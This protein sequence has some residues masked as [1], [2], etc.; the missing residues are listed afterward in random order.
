MHDPIGGF[1]RI[2]DLY[3][4]YL[5]TAFR[6]RDPGV[7]AERRAL[8]E[9]PG[10]LCTEPLVEPVP[11]YAPSGVGLHDLVDGPAAERVLPGFSRAQRLAFAE[12]ALAGLFDATPAADG[13]ATSREAAYPLYEH[14]ATML[15]RGVQQGRPGVVTSGTGS[16]KTE[17]FL[18]PILASIVREATSWD[19]P[20]PGYLGRRWWHGDDGR[21]AGWS[22]LPNRPT[23]ADPGATPFRPH[24][25]GERRPA[26]VRALVLYPMNAL[27]EDQLTRVRK[28]LDSDEARRVMDRHLGGNRIFFGRYTSAAPVTG[29]HVHPRPAADEPDRRARKLR[30]LL[31][32]LGEVERTQA[33]ARAHDAA[34][35]RDGRDE[36]PTRFLFPSTD[37][38]EL[39]T[40]WDMQ[41]TPP[42]LLVTN[43]SMLNAMLVRE[44][45]A[46]VFETTRAWLES[47]PDAYFYLVLDELHLQRGSAGTEVAYLLRVLLDRLGLTR[48]EH[49]HKLR[50]LASSASLPVDG[51]ER[52]Q[53]LRYLYDAFGLHGT[54]TAGGPPAQTGPEAWADAVV[55]GEPVRP[56]PAETG[57]LPSEPFLALLDAYG[58]ADRTAFDAPTAHEDDWRA[59][60]TALGLTPDGPAAHVAGA[61]VAEAGARLA[62]ACVGDPARPGGDPVPRATPTSTLAERL[63]GAS[64]PDA[65]RALRGLLV[66]RGAGGPLRGAWADDRALARRVDQAPSFR[67]HTFFRAVEGL[68]AAPDEAG[69]VESP[70]RTDGRS[71]GPL[72][73]ERGERFAKRADRTRGHRVLELLYCECC[74]ET[75]YG[76]RRGVPPGGQADG[77]QAD[78]VELLPHEPEVAGLPDASRTV[79]FEDLSY[80]EFAVFWPSTRTPAE[81]RSGEPESGSWVP[82][83]LDPATGVVRRSLLGG[84]G[85]PG[86]LYYRPPGYEDSQHHLVNGDD[87]TAVPFACPFCGTN[88]GRR[89]RSMRLSPI[90]SFRAGFAKTTQILATEL[91]DALRVHQDDAKLLSFS[92]SRQEASRAA[93][94]VESGH[95]ADLRLDLL[96]GALRQAARARRADDPDEL[97]RL[98]TEAA[99]DGHYDLA[100]ALKARRL[101]AEAGSSDDAVPMS[102][103]VESLQA[104]D[105]R[106][107]GADP[108]APLRPFLAG[109][110]RLGLHPTD[111]AGTATVDVELPTGTRRLHW[112]DLFELRA[113]PAG[114]GAAEPVADW[115]D[116][117][118][119]AHELNKAREAVVE[120]A[121]RVLSDALFSRNYFALEETGLG[122]PCALGVDA[123]ARGETD[124]FLRVLTDA[125][126]LR[127]NPYAKETDAPPK[128]WPDA[129]VPKQNRVRAFAKAVWPDH[130][131]DDRLL[132]LLERLADAGHPGGLV[133]T[134]ALGVR[135][136]GPDAPF[137]RC[138]TCGRV[139]L[140]RGAEACT[141]CFAR[142]PDAPAGTAAELRERHYLAKRVGRA[143]A[144]FRIRCEELTGQTHDPADRQR[145]FRGVVLDAA[146]SDA[147]VPPHVGDELRRRASVVDLLT[148]TTTMEVGVDV[149]S[150]QATVQAN[151]PPQRF[152]YQQRVGRAGRRRQAYSVVLT[153]CRNRNHD[154]HYFRHPEAITGDAPPPP[155]LSKDLAEPA[156]RFARKAWLWKAFDHLR[157]GLAAAGEPFPGDA[158]RPPDV[159]GEFVPTADYAGDPDWRAQL[160]DALAETEGYK[161]H[162]LAVLAEDADLPGLRLDPDG[163]VA[164]IAGVLDPDSPTRLEATAAGLGQTLAEAGLL[165]M[166]GMPTRVR[167]LYYAYDAPDKPWE[168][169]E[170]KTV[171]RDL[172]VAVF[173]FAPGSVLV[174]DKRQIEAIGFTAPIPQWTK[175]APGATRRVFDPGAPALSAPFWLV[176]CDACNGTQRFDRR[177]S[178]HDPPACA[179]CGASLDVTALAELRVPN[180]FRTDLHPKPFDPESRSP[181]RG[182]FGLVAQ[183]HPAPFGP[184]DG[185]PLA[186][187]YD[188]CVRTYRVNEGPG[189]G[190]AVTQVRDWRYGPGKTAIA[191]QVVAGDR[192]EVR[193]RF[194]EET[195]D[196]P[197]TVDAL[198]LAAPKTTDALFLAPRTPP[199][200]LAL[201][202]R[203]G[204]GRPVVAVRAAA[205][206]AAFLLT[207]RAAQTLDVDPDELEVVE[208]RVVRLARDA[209]RVPLLQLTDQLLNGAGYCR[210]LAEPD[211]DGVPLVLRLAR[212]VVGDPAVSPLRELV[213]PDHA[214]RC[215][216]ACYRCLQRYGNQAYHGLLDWRLGLAY[217]QALTDP[218]YACGLD[219]ADDDPALVDWDELAQT[220]AD[221]L[222]RFDGVGSVEPAGD[223][224]SFRLQPGGPWALVVH[225]LWNLDRPGPRLA[226]AYQAL[227]RRGDSWRCVDT[228]RLSR[229]ALA[230]RHDLGSA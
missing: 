136:V 5:E 10:E 149:G 4:T 100:K 204:E 57:T 42:D 114:D 113:D 74:G 7:S 65:L 223:L 205:L 55:P 108:R 50:V 137:W 66:A 227:V 138:A 39:V 200:H 155:F 71:V 214:T 47:D 2:R 68:F 229:A 181:R 196:D 189:E 217:L 213:D 225:P 194:D 197:V 80:D 28:A 20:D 46:P 103:V 216:P 81:R 17:S 212:S 147:G 131:V 37:G 102:A 21:P 130:E 202:P 193:K 201:L 208:P 122:Y 58:G 143:A 62:S 72:T 152:N 23:K 123:A 167:N 172:D 109:F 16:G 139:H 220:Y 67:V 91:F 134:D 142:L 27:V 19:A 112:A 186:V 14:Q 77:G 1:E 93:L 85:A 87:G 166:L 154:L 185:H 180:G 150:L 117:P 8:L 32:G 94:D 230:V 182:G 41:A 228:F 76:G 35:A 18:L 165:P 221:N 129:P 127:D 215:D 133:A 199:P 3:L 60:A 110:V 22:A 226:R 69:A 73:I 206:S 198:H 13:A 178:P 98:E 144:P 125:Y 141:R 105:F 211:G 132:V 158:L 30:Q 61:V 24:R 119:R 219:G 179:A 128:R 101:A 56:T 15:A 184:P 92:D 174:N 9:R 156:L 64:G 63:F 115:R 177:P 70:F 43:T 45:D 159:H 163:L 12:V 83:L 146:P 6:I 104:G 11:R 38:A 36:D 86:R 135:L 160:R 170:W 153:V 209:P 175:K 116:D 97:R 120:Q 59:A 54:W 222:V 34:A 29:H 187:A 183:S 48:P 162:L 53:S 84:D 126:R 26:A 95:Y 145:R 78:V 168:R 124:A 176:A 173:E 121:Q 224:V 164:E 191:R 195:A 31:D 44:V 79:L 90:R 148:V 40:R 111:P 75:F 106:T 49:R 207:N 161:D 140:H 188:Q 192:D 99:L 190:Y 218:A 210:R 171:D 33:A 169:T 25:E 82:A 96:V 157:A 118:D 88:Y 203:D 151:M 52:D 107:A 51:P 89:K